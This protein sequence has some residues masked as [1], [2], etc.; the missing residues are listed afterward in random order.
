MWRT[1]AAVSWFRVNV[2]W[3][4]LAANGI[5]ITCS[6]SYHLSDADFL[7]MLQ[8]AVGKEKSLAQVLYRGAQAADHPVLL[9]MPETRYLKCLALQ[10]LDGLPN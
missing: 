9:S 6:C 3:N 2:P 4:R 8:N 1:G 10:K 7:E 5:L